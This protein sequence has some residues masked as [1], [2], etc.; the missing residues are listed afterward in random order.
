MMI[1]KYPDE[2][3]YGCNINELLKNYVLDEYK[4]PDRL[5]MIHLNEELSND[6]SIVFDITNDITLSFGKITIDKSTRK[7]SNVYIDMRY[8]TVKE[9]NFHGYIFDEYIGRKIQASLDWF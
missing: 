8:F 5:L 9:S 6:D 3:W 2:G 1:N 4:N 7:I